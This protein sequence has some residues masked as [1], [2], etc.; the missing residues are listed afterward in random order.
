MKAPDPSRQG[1]SEPSPGDRRK[2][3]FQ[4]QRGDDIM[5]AWSLL[6]WLA[7]GAVAGLVARGFIGGTP[8]FGKVGDLAL[9]IAGAVVGGFLLAALGVGGTVG[10][11][12]GTCITALTG[13]L[14]LVW[15]SNRI[16]VR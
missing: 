5:P 10:G 8:P 13:A 1:K 12:I 9:G 7:I 14:L 11:L 15:L 4:E 16:K 6:V 2:T 3:S